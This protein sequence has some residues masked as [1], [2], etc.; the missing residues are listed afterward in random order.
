[1][2]VVDNS[3][4]I[5]WLVGEGVRSRAIDQRLRG[6]RMYAP[7]LL[8][9]EAVSVLRRL[10]L[11]DGASPEVAQHALVALGRLTLERVPHLPL[12]PRI[13]ELRDNL[14]PYD[15]AYVALAEQLGVPLLTVDAKL[16]ASPGIRCAVELVS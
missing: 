7:E 13:W 14:T 16:A 11:V 12:V 5:E 15:A 4:V 6:E 10:V 2:I 8:D 3:A 1:M 9:L